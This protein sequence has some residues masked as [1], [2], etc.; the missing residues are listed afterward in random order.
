MNNKQRIIL[1]I[2]ALVFVALGLYPPWQSVGSSVEP[3]C[4]CK[5]R[6]LSEETEII[7]SM[8]PP[9]NFIALSSIP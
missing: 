8:L 9:Q 4:Y 3:G 7:P 1:L 2:G 6:W 5:G